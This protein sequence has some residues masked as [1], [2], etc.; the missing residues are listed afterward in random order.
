MWVPLI[1]KAFAKF[2][3][4]Y[5]RLEGGYVHTALSALTGG[6]PGKMY[7]SYSSGKCLLTVILQ[8]IRRRSG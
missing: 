2:Y 4:S 3:G 1:E 7:V 6:L 5:E 8:S